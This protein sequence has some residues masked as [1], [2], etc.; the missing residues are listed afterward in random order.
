MER[1]FFENDLV[2]RD[3][4]DRLRDAVYFVDH[5]GSIL[6]MNKAAEDLDGLKFEDVRGKTVMDVY[7]L[8]AAESPLLRVVCN[9]EPLKEHFFRYYINDR[10]VYQICNTFPI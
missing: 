3:I 8:T 5:D 2:M 10:E 1:D 6:F 7:N 9:K 4:F